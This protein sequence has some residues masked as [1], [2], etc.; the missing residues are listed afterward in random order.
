MQLGGLYNAV[1]DYTTRWTPLTFGG[2]ALF[3]K[4]NVANSVPA[5][6]TDFIPVL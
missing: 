3:P 5:V 6:R 1:A 4:W 2:S